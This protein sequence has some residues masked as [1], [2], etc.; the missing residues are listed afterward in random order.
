MSR[1]A[2][3]AA[4]ER[5]VGGLIRSCRRIEH[6]YDGRRFV[7]FER[8]EMV[9]VCGG[10]GV[11]AARRAT[12]AVIGLYSPTLVQSV[13]FAG[14]LD[15]SLRA[16]DVFIPAV[17]IDGRDGSRVEVDDE[18]REGQGQGQS[19]LVTFMAVAGAQQKASLA[20]AYGAQ[21]VDME[22]AAVAA[23]AHAHGVRFGAMKVISDEIGF[24]MPEMTR[25]ID[26]QGRFRTANFAAFVAFRPG[27]WRRVSILARNCQKAA[28][29]LGKH[30][31]HYVS[32]KPLPFPAT[33]QPA[34][35]A[36]AA[37]GLSAGGRE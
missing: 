21:A 32:E 17:V 11:E 15:A 34:P 35:P 12:E 30:L 4:L 33:V 25:F 28:R 37:S 16:G 36:A 13:G 7:F 9:L 10:I 6:Q 20:R 3:V 29:E 5:E 18:A 2:I 8:D 23:A 22:A 26:A 24:E 19:K 1:V 14:A 31:E 27:L